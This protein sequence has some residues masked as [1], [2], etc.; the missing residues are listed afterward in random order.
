MNTP[1]PPP[2]YKLV[3]GIDII[4]YAECASQLTTPSHPVA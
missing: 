3:K 1:T 4:G 2:G